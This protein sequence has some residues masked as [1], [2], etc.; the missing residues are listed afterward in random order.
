LILYP[1]REH[2]EPPRED[3][4]RGDEDTRGGLDHG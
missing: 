2:R 3:H 4:D 1:P